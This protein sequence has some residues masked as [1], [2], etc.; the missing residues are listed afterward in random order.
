MHP[1]FAL[2]QGVWIARQSETEEAGKG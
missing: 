2:L 1:V